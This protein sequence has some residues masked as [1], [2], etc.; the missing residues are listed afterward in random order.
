[1]DKNDLQAMF[2][3][4]TDSGQDYV[5]AMLLHMLGEGPSPVEAGGPEFAVQASEIGLVSGDQEA[6]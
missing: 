3:R 1:M 6:P 4:L 2:N 5:V